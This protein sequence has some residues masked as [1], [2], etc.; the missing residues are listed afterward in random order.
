M[1]DTLVL[2]GHRYTYWISPRKV[3]IDKREQLPDGAWT[4]PKTVAVFRHSDAKAVHDMTRQFD[5]AFELDVL[6]DRILANSRVA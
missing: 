1:N 3:Q 2:A 6:G 4:L 5:T